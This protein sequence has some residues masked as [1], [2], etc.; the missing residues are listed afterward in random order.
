MCIFKRRKV[1]LGILFIV[2][3]FFLPGISGA[4]AGGIDNN[5]YL[6]I[7]GSAVCV[8][9]VMHAM[10]EG[11]IYKSRIRDRVMGVVLCGSVGVA[12]ELLIDTSLDAIDIGANFLGLAMAVFLDTKYFD[13]LPANAVPRGRFRLVGFRPGGIL[14]VGMIGGTNAYRRSR[15]IG[16]SIAFDF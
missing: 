2:F 11:Q 16:I 5:T 6:H 1:M 13:D 3:G 15:P 8:L 14:N 9:G 7:G 12:K 10:R 4:G